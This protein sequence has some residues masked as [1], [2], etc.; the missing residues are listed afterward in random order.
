MHAHTGASVATAA[1][2]LVFAACGTAA[3][4]SAANPSPSAPGATAAPSANTAGSSGDFAGNVAIGNGRGLYL[5]C[6]G[7]GGPTVIFISGFGNAGDIWY[8]T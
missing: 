8:Q 2:C 4:G 1:L 7:R 5:E 6:H 3:P